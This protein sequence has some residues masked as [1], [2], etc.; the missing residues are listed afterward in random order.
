MEP[1][2]AH[3]EAI[4]VDWDTDAYK[5]DFKHAIADQTQEHSS[6]VACQER[7][8]KEQQWTL[9][10]CFKSFCQEEELTAYCPKCKENKG[11][12]T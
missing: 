9:D 1:P 3:W 8:V 6:V 2:L 5:R 12:Y 7:R 10:N 11:E 4:A